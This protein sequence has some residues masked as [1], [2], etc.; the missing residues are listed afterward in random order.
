M[1]E[2]ESMNREEFIEN[3]NERFGFN[4]KTLNLI[5]KRWGENLPD[6][7]KPY[8]AIINEYKSNGLSLVVIEEELNSFKKDHLHSTSSKKHSLDT[9]EGTPE[10]YQ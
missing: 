1:T 4:K 9:Q 6:Y 5:V 8:N 10:W 2:R 3:L 7:Q